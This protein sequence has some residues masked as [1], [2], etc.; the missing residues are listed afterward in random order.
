MDE[1]AIFEL[2]QHRDKII[3]ASRLLGRPRKE[4]AEYFR[5]SES[6]VRQIEYNIKQRIKAYDK[7]RPDS[8]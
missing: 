5:I 2:M 6:R 1:K 8:V 7:R 4:L 3:F